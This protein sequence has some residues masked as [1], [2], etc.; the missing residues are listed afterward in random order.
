M[1]AF[2][3]NLQKYRELV[4]DPMASEGRSWGMLDV[5]TVLTSGE[6]VTKEDIEL[7]KLSKQFGESQFSATQVRGKGT[8]LKL[9]KLEALVSEGI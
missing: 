5:G 1:F 2:G 8:E 4:F 9:V 3:G 7:L 6:V